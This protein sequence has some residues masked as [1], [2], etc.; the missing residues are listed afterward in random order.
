M[1]T[2]LLTCLSIGCAPSFGIVFPL[3]RQPPWEATLEKYRQ[4]ECLALP[5]R[6][7]QS[8]AR[9]RSF[10]GPVPCPRRSRHGGAIRG[11][12]GLGRVRPCESS[13]ADPMRVATQNTSPLA[14]AGRL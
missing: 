3:L 9:R 7:P 2:R 12:G 4:A 5:R 10:Y 14:S 1:R 11:G 8:R 6:P 13:F